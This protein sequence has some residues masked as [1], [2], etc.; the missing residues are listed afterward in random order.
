M[1]D[2][3]RVLSLFRLPCIL[4]TFQHTSL[5]THPPS[6]FSPRA[7]FFVPLWH[8]VHSSLTGFM[9]NVYKVYLVFMILEE[10]MI[11]ERMKFL[12]GLSTWKYLTLIDYLTL[13]YTKHVSYCTNYSFG[14]KFFIENCNYTK[15]LYGDEIP[16]NDI[17]R[18]RKIRL[19]ESNYQA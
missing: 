15:F 3:I 16:Y 13:N 6:N 5:A 19:I 14:L 4:Y 9:K 8:I 18:R 12:H 17:V 11:I 7:Q 10:C 2:H 1:V